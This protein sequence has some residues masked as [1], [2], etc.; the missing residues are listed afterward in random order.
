METMMYITPAKRAAALSIRCR[1]HPAPCRV[2]GRQL[3]GSLPGG[4]PLPAA[5]GP[6]ARRGAHGEAICPLTTT[7]LCARLLRVSS[8]DV[9]ALKG[10]P[11][12]PIASTALKAPWKTATAKDQNTI[13]GRDSTDRSRYHRKHVHNAGATHL[14]LLSPFGD[15][16]STGI[17]APKPPVC[18][19]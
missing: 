8:I 12:N 10:F 1:A 17:E 3:H 13:A 7:P 5:R 19:S 15:L 2:S 4:K 16:H 14:I 18:S 11:V 9:Y 6:C